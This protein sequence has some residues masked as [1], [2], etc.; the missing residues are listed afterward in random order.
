MA[1]GHLKVMEK[2]WNFIHHSQC[3]PCT[4]IISIPVTNNTFFFQVYGNRMKSTNEPQQV[5]CIFEMSYCKAMAR[6]IC[7]VKEKKDAFVG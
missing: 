6:I 3:E 5:A 2:S 4:C 7:R 1:F